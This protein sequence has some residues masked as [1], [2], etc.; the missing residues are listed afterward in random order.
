[1]HLGAVTKPLVALLL[2][3]CL[4]LEV[5]A[6]D[7]TPGFVSR[8][9]AVTPLPALTEAARA[10]R[11]PLDQIDPSIETNLVLPGD[12]FTAVVTLYAKRPE[13]QWLLYLQAVE[14]TPKE[15]AENSPRTMVIY[16][17]LGH[18][19]EFPSAP[20]FV[21]LRTVGPF[22]EGE[23]GKK[24]KDVTTRFVLDQGF[25]G[26][27]LEQAA[28]AILRMGKSGVKGPFMS[29]TEPFGDEVM[30]KCRQADQTWHITPAEE[31]AVAGTM[32]ALLSYF[33]TAQE[34]PELMNIMVKAL[35]RPSVWSLLW[36]VGISSTEFR[37]DPQRIV[38][39]EAS[40]W[41]VSGNPA[42]YYCPMTLSLNHHPSLD[43]TMVVTA[44]HPPLLSCGGVLGVLAEKPGDKQI[45]LTLRIVSA[46]LAAKK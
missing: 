36:H 43:L 15:Q 26:L 9:A 7:P 35:D 12:S 32:P 3:L 41:R 44:P 1:V 40:A 25:L 37:W 31:R 46:R 19:L 27:G 24:P 6:Q 8:L 16:N 21:A 39:A 10:N 33:K 14:P 42:A 11:I 22:V 45:Y 20:A 23:T 29:G 30:G 38:P 17:T 4:R 28:A 34:A 18:K 5:S 13:M 2:V